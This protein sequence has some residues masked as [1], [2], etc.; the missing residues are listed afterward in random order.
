[1]YNEINSW[2]S[3]DINK[4]LLLLKN[5]I[6]KE[7]ELSC[8]EIFSAIKYEY[9][10]EATSPDFYEVVLFRDDVIHANNEK[11]K[12]YCNNFRLYTPR[13]Y[14]I[15]LDLSDENEINKYV[16]VFEK[17]NRENSLGLSYTYSRLE[18]SVWTEEEN[19]PSEIYNYLHDVVAE[20]ALKEI[21]EERKQ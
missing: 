21:L 8:D 20:N 9:T 7:D 18:D 15:T 12:L 14:L 5:S 6:K 2:I 4:E 16:H 13:M 10:V 17:Q 3:F 19:I 1:M 11:Q